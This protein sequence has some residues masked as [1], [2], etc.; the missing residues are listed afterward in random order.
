M[1]ALSNLTHFPTA[2]AIFMST[3]FLHLW[4]K[5]SFRI[6]NKSKIDIFHFLERSLYCFINFY[7]IWYL[8]ME[9]HQFFKCYIFCCLNLFSTF[10]A[11]IFKSVNV[12]FIIKYYTIILSLHPNVN[13]SLYTCMC[14]CT[15]KY[16]TSDSVK[17]G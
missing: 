10:F 17:C 4:A 16:Y 6:C 9:T 14:V 5:A 1:C 15:Y 13:F 8:N 2:K 3:L 7:I 11:F 12:F